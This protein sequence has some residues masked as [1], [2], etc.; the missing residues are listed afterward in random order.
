MIVP[1]VFVAQCA[2]SPLDG[3]NEHVRAENRLSSKKANSNQST[4]ARRRHRLRRWSTAMRTTREVGTPSAPVT[5]DTPHTEHAAPS[6]ASAPANSGARAKSK[7]PGLLRDLTDKV[8]GRKETA[9]AKRFTDSQLEVALASPNFSGGRTTRA[10]LREAARREARRAAPEADAPIGRSQ[11]RPEQTPP[12]DTPPARKTSVL[13]ERVR[14]A[15]DRVTA[16]TQNAE[17][18]Q[19]S[20]EVLATQLSHPGL[21]SGRGLRAAQREAARR[22]LVSGAADDQVATEGQAPTSGVAGAH[23]PQGPVVDV[24]TGE[25]SNVHLRETV[26]ALIDRLP[27]IPDDVATRHPTAKD[28]HGKLEEALRSVATVAANGTRLSPD[29]MLVV[30]DRFAKAARAATTLARY[31]DRDRVAGRSERRDATS[32]FLIAG[33]LTELKRTHLSMAATALVDDYAEREVAKLERVAPGISHG[34]S[35]PNVATST[36]GSL[37]YSHGIGNAS[38]GGSA[39][40][41]IFADD[42]RD[43]DFWTSYSIALKGG[44][45]GKIKKWAASLTGQAGFSGGGTYLEHD[46]LR[47][48]VK[49]IANHDANQSWITSAGP[50]TRK[51]VHGWESFRSNASRLMGRNY[52]QETS[53]PYFAADKKLEKGFNGVKTALLAMALDEHLPGKSFSS[54]M[55]TA[56]PAVGDTLRERVGTGLP[57]PRATRADVPDSVAYADRRVAFRQATLGVEGDLGNQTNGG[58]PLEAG[59]T[60]SLIGKGDLIQFFVETANAP[61]QLLDPGYH[62]DLRATLGLHRKLDELSAESPPPELHLYATIQ[63]QLGGTRALGQ[64]SDADRHLYGDEASIPAQFHEAIAHPSPEHLERAAAQAARLEAMYLNFVE[65]GAQILAKPDKF[66]PSGAR[67]QL[68]SAR[69]E[70]FARLNEEVWNGRYDEAKA[71]A[72]PEEFVSR[73]HAAL[74]LG[75]GAVGTH[76][77]IVK[78]RLT[79]NPNPSHADSIMHADLAYATTRELF[80]KLYLPMKKYDVQKGGPLKDK[81]VWQRWDALVRLQASGGAQSSVLN[82]IA[83]RWKKS[84][85]PVSISNAAGEV[86]LSAEAKFLY[87]DRQINPSRVGKFWQITLT[88][89]AGAPLTG[90]AVQKAVYGAVKRLNSALATDEP[91]I[92]PQ[93]AIRQ[94]QGLALDTT[95]GT[96]IVMKFRQAPG[97]KMSSTDLQY[98]RVLS[99]NNSGLNASVT[100]PT[101][102]GTFTPGISHTDSAQGFQGEVIGPDLSYLMLQHPKLTALL[103][104]RGSDVPAQ[105]KQLLD[106]NPRVRD[107]YFG[108]STTI[109]ETVSRYVDFMSAKARAAERG[110]PIETLPMNNEFH[111]YYAQAPFARVSQVSRHVQSHAPGSTAAGAQ[112]FET[113]APL[114]QE[115]DIPGGIDLEKAKDDL[116][117]MTTVAERVEYFANEGRPLLNA[118]A[119]IVSNTRAINAAAMFHTEARNIGIETGLRDEQALR[120]QK[121]DQQAASAG[122]VSQAAQNNAPPPVLPAVESVPALPLGEIERLANA[123]QPSE[124][125]DAARAALRQRLFD[126]S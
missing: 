62:K 118:F 56:Y 60:F 89:Q 57:L 19:F 71:L 16:K 54:L 105:F 91:K 77:G 82:A 116:G 43:I 63:R 66:M 2:I 53:T 86:T 92:D 97:A 52:V 14:E 72:N 23:L 122:Q 24:E 5:Q 99:D 101:H 47:Q 83:G 110:V 9:R 93:E 1:G 98:V 65:D 126:L 26:D 41:T 76:I 51:L 112:P 115:V 120:S 20:D 59:G 12:A 4:S 79:Q 48:L 42:D 113:A 3:F 102:V 6:P 21:L 119:A 81:A 29:K 17:A 13:P 103:D 117:K 80:D 10:L 61:H 114:S 58:T 15:L 64:L 36:G 38:I 95:D 94:V 85:A 39:G 73:T 124:Q 30:R 22:Q 106:A 28:L 104:A 88:A 50:K 46:D 32:Y 37:S 55:E 33:L 27:P 111:R 11:I 75:L 40:R 121:G 69:S 31:L 68:K 25:M 100:L 84:L 45:G 35:G 49:L 44:I 8:T 87:A 34:V 74:S 108:T 18:A 125:R 67:A 123:T 7:M 90:L 96:S 107:G 109:V 70:A 78:E